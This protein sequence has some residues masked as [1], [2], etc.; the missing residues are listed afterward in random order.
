MSL[1]D[2]S[3]DELPLC[4]LARNQNN[5]TASGSTNGTKV[6]GSTPAKVATDSAQLAFVSRST[7]V[8]TKN[9]LLT[10][11]SNSIAVIQSQLDNGDPVCKR[12]IARYSRF[13]LRLESLVSAFNAAS[14][15]FS[16]LA[17]RSGKK[18]QYAGGICDILNRLEMAL[19]QLETGQIFVEGSDQPEISWDHILNPAKRGSLLRE[20]KRHTNLKSKQLGLSPALVNLIENV[21][22]EQQEKLTEYRSI[23]LEGFLFKLHIGFLG[24]KWLQAYKRKTKLVETERRTETPGDEM[25]PTIDEHWG[26][27]EWSLYFKGM[28]LKSCRIP[29]APKAIEPCNRSGTK[30]PD[31]VPAKRSKAPLKHGKNKQSN[32]GPK[33]SASGVRN[34]YFKE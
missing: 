10:F 13:A 25:L 33:F 29:F 9:A 5:E 8:A 19:L 4:F 12:F 14:D 3:D 24:Q 30:N 28:L 15:L 6:G 20:L 1:S 27:N 32:S 21:I 26:G 23:A 22:K 34:P 31:K 11:V 16:Q 18:D 7:N 2:S 17:S